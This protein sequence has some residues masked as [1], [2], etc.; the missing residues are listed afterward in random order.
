[1]AKKRRRASKSKASFNRKHP[2]R[3]DGTFKPKAHSKKR[4][5]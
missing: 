1:M 2:R 5:R 3:A 4:R